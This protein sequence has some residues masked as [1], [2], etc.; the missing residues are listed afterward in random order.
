MQR[1]VSTLSVCDCLRHLAGL[2]RGLALKSTDP[3]A[4]AHTTAVANR[5]DVLIEL[6]GGKAPEKGGS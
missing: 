5:C 4:M 1:D 6:M 2:M 3:A